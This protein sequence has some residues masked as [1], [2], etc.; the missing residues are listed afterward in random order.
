MEKVILC[1]SQVLREYCKN[2]FASSYIAQIRK[3]YDTQKQDMQKFEAEVRTFVK[4]QL[5]VN[6]FQH[7]LTEIAFLEIRRDHHNNGG[8]GIIPITLDGG[9][10]GIDSLSGLSVYL[11][12]KST[13]GPSPPHELFFDLLKRLYPFRCESFQSYYKRY[14]NLRQWYEEDRKE[15]SLNDKIEK[16]IRQLWEEQTKR[17]VSGFRDKDKKVSGGPATK[18]KRS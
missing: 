1:V 11:K 3:L 6:G 18:S 7:V 13:H 12:F 8:D 4:S 2:E 16:E 5:K 17:A 9:E 10:L 15:M 14:E